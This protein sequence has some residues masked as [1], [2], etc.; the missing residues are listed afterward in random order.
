MGCSLCSQPPPSRKLPTI[1]LTRALFPRLQWLQCPAT[2]GYIGID[3]FD[4]RLQHLHLL[5]CPCRVC[6]AN[7]TDVDPA[8]L[9]RVLVCCTCLETLRVESVPDFTVPTMLDPDHLI[10]PRLRQLELTRP[11]R[12]LHCFGCCL[13]IPGRYRYI[14]VAP[15]SNTY[16]SFGTLSR[17]GALHLLPDSAVHKRCASPIYLVPVCTSTSSTLRPTENTNHGRSGACPR[18]TSVPISMRF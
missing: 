13:S 4:D 7:G 2:F 10:L 1:T 8:D 14:S 18:V 3:S 17:Q 15:A 11:T 16:R 6:Q 12:P 5:D 9:C